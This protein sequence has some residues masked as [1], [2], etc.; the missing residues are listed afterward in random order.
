MVNNNR[1]GR[2]AIAEYKQVRLGREAQIVLF[3]GQKQHQ[4]CI[5]PRHGMVS[6]RP[7]RPQDDLH[8]FAGAADTKPGF[9]VPSV[10]T[11]FTVVIRG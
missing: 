10:G 2:D 9:A 6:V 1:A 5:G 4:A 8:R 3:L 7:R 11:E